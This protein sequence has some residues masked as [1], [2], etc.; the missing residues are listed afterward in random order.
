MLQAEHFLPDKKTKSQGKS[1]VS[2]KI[3]QQLMLPLA[4]A[5]LQGE[6]TLALESTDSQSH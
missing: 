2:D 5:Q 1:R 3:T 4:G 6:L